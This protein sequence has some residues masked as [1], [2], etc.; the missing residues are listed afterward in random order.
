MLGRGSVKQIPIKINEAL[1]ATL[2]RT[3]SGAVVFWL[4]DSALHY[5]GYEEREHYPDFVEPHER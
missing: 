1:R 2:G 3:G 4:F 5:Y